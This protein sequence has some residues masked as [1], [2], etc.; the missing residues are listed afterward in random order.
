MWEF[1]NLSENCNIDARAPSTWGGGRSRRLL[2]S[3]YTLAFWCL[4]RFDEVSQIRV[5]HLKLVN[6]TSFELSLPFRKTHQYGSMSSVIIHKC[7]I[8]M[9][10]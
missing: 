1:N 6:F 2:Q 9:A 8:D 3:A 7:S 5:S 4:L 10:L